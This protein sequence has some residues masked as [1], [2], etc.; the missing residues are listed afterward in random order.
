MD[1]AAVPCGNEQG[2]PIAHDGGLRLCRGV[3]FFI[4]SALCVAG[5]LRAAEVRHQQPVLIASPSIGR[6]IQAALLLQER[7]YSRILV[8]AE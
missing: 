4:A 1:L 3:W 6:S 5:A 8:I 2:E 7:G